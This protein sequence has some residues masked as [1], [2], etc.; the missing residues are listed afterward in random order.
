MGTA[1][2]RG[3]NEIHTNFFV[4]GLLMGTTLMNTA[5]GIR[6]LIRARRNND[7]TG[8]MLMKILI[9]V[10]VVTLALQILW[11]LKSAGR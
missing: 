7:G 5:C 3:V 8:I 9:A 1:H 6:E 2:E 10:S 11:L 4:C